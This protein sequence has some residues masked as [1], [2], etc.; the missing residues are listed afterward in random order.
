MSKSIGGSGCLWLLDAP[1]VSAKKIRSAV[2]DTGREV[3]FDAVAKPGVSNLLTIL[4]ALSDTEIPVLQE[5]FAGA[6][7]GDLKKEVAAAYLAFAE[8]FTARANELLA[9]PDT[10]DDVLAEGARRARAEAAPLL[11]QVYDRVGFLPGKW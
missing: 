2:T 5:R 1:K 10:L 8:P 3:T 11:A 9:D 4:S 6:G 7:Y